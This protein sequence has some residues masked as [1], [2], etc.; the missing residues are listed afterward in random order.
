MNKIWWIVLLVLLGIVI[1]G[2]AYLR[3]EFWSGLF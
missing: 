3:L 2:G 1:I